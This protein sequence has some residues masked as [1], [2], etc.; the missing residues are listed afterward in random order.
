MCYLHWRK[1]YQQVVQKYAGGEIFK[2][3]NSCPKLSYRAHILNSC[4]LYGD[5]RHKILPGLPWYFAVLYLCCPESCVCWK[6]SLRCVWLN[7]AVHSII[8]FCRAPATVGIIDTRHCHLH[9]PALWSHRL[10]W[11]PEECSRSSKP[12][13]TMPPLVQS[14]SGLVVFITCQEAAGV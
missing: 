8:Q 6:C 1:S 12:I 5:I 7:T 4:I 3:S 9:C 11:S 2:I 10:R 13:F 14:L